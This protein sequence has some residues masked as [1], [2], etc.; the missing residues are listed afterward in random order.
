MRGALWFGTYLVLILFPLV[1]GAV[2]PGN[3]AGKPFAMQFGIACGF[4]GLSVMAFEY[5]MISRVRTLA[6]AFGQD[7]LL[8]LHRLMGILA[9]VLLVVHAVLMVML[10]GYPPEWL[11][12]FSPDSPWAMRWGVLAGCLLMVLIF[13]SIFRKR[14]RLS[15][16]WWQLTHHWLADFIV[17]MGLVH[18]VM[19]EGFSS[20]KAMRFCL[21]FYYIVM[22]AIGVNTRL[23]RPLRLW[24][25]RWELVENRVERGGSRTLVLKPHNHDGLVF[26]PG[27]FAWLSTGNNPFHKDRHPISFSSCAYDRNGSEISFTIR[28][29]GDWSGEVVPKLSPGQLIWVDGPHGVF[30]ADRDQ[31]MGYVLFGGGVGITPMK[32]ICSTLAERGDSRPVI[33]FYASRD[34]EGLTFFEEFETLKKRMNLKIVYVLGDC[35]DGWT[36]ERGYI[37]RNMIEKYLPPH[38]KRYQFFICGPPAMMDVIEEAL[39]ALGVPPQHVHSERFDMV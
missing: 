20:T 34:V 38:F 31:G 27:Q 12:P 2:D 19:F 24:G 32:S 26:E 9:T 6:G 1:I 33:L 4:V 30:T 15:Y 35:P 21:A 8:Q 23:V 16:G 14:I 11:N 18:V 5:A 3:G 29:L 37:D 22:I 25:R 10:S 39:P 36:G 7:A 13:L 28:N 17:A